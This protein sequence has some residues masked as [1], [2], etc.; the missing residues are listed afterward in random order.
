MPEPSASNEPVPSASMLPELGLPG[1]RPDEPAGEYGWTGA[2]HSSGG[3][4][5]VIENQSSPDAFR[6]TQLVVA[7]KNVCFPT[8]LTAT[9]AEPTAVTVAG[10]DGFY[11]EGHTT[12]PSLLF[13]SPRGGSTTGAYALPIGDR[14]LCAYLTWDRATTAD[15]L[16]AA[17]EVLE[18]IRGQPF[19]KDGIRPATS[20]TPWERSWSSTPRSASPSS[21]SWARCSSCGSSV[22]PSGASHPI[23]IAHYPWADDLARSEPGRLTSLSREPLASH[24]A[25]GPT[26]RSKSHR[27]S[28]S[29]GSAA[30]RNRGLGGMPRTATRAVQRV[31]KPDSAAEWFEGAGLLKP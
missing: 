27:G 25:Y 24:V 21:R 17:R 6:Q 31:W 19:G 18:S 20:S 1:T 4:H 28:V 16:N 30:R 10:V 12:N 29:R 7:V 26:K 15:E 23:S 5:W 9:G 8:S 22:W 11:L 3:M 13:S 14:T 2:L